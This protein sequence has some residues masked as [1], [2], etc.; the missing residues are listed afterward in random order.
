MGKPVEVAKVAREVEVEVTDEKEDEVSVGEG[1]SEEEAGEGDDNEKVQAEEQG[2]G[3]GEELRS[4]EEEEGDGDEGEEDAADEIKED[5]EQAEGDG[6]EGEQVEGEGDEED[7][8]EGEGEEGEGDVKEDTA[9]S[10]PDA[11]FQLPDGGEEEK[12]GKKASA[13]VLGM[14]PKALAKF[15]AAVANTGVVYLSR[16]PPFMKVSAFLISSVYRRVS[17]NAYPPP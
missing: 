14:T 5:H 1:D 13:P 8:E 12:K 4:E 2:E 10:G 6:S 16:I 9:Y 17:N 11:R 15:T 3:D 7:A